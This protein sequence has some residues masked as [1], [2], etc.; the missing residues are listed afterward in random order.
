MKSWLRRGLL[1][2]SV[3]ALF[4][5]AAPAA[6]QTYLE[7]NPPIPGTVVTPGY[8]MQIAVDSVQ[9]GFGLSY[10]PCGVPSELSVSEVTITKSTGLDS[11]ALATAMRDNATNTGA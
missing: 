2:A 4:L 3:V 1:L 9:Y 10:Q 5:A 6:A 11:I 7:T 8:E